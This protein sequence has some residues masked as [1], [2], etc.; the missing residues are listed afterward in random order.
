MSDSDEFREGIIPDD[1]NPV[2]SAFGAIT[3]AF[4]S[5]T[6][7]LREKE[8][9]EEEE[10]ADGS[11]TNEEDVREETAEMAEEPSEETEAEAAADE[12]DPD[13]EWKRRMEEPPSGRKK[14]RKLPKEP[15]FGFLKKDR[16]KQ[17]LPEDV[18]AEDEAVPDPEEGQEDIDTTPA[19]ERSFEDADRS[20]ADM[21]DSYSPENGQPDGHSSDFEDRQPEE[22][23][24]GNGQPEEYSTE[25]GQ[26]DEYGS[27]TGPEEGPGTQPAEDE[28]PE[29]SIEVID[30]D[31]NTNSK[32]A[33]VIP[34]DA[35]STGPL[36]RLKA[37]RF[38]SGRKTVQNP[39]EAAKKKEKKEKKQPREPKEP[40][41]PNETWLKIRGFIS[42]HRRQC[43]I[44]LIALLALIGVIAACTLIF[45]NMQSR[46]RATIR[47]R[48]CAMSR[49]ITRRR[50]GRSLTR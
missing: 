8:P 49:P 35:R 40:K 21:E 15:L 34:L 7:R 33:E 14:R 2:R 50:S 44:G 1:S 45:S 16:K 27:E 39:G 23:S 9:K 41:K 36:P 38:L 46:R 13:E 22:Y 11:S 31:E 42:S 24:S 3:G 47:L 12:Y 48:L 19:S 25:N 29:K 18:S 28:Y 6:E 37:G 10:A 17:E 43:L 32:E 30:L 26:P 5:L 20:G 4:A